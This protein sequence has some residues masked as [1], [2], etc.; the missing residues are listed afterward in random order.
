MGKSIKFKGGYYLDASAVEVKSTSNAYRKTLASLLAGINDT[1]I[2]TIGVSAS[3]TLTVGNDTRALLWLTGTSANVT[4]AI[5]V[6]CTAGGI[7][8]AYKVAGASDISITTAT[9]S[10]TLTNANTSNGCSINTLCSVG[11]ISE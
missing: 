7:T 6:A 9:N 11:N 2:F 8:L 3:K 5:G 4:G 1:K 10:L